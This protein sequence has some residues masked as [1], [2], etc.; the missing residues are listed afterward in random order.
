MAMPV[1]EHAE[2]DGLPVRRAIIGVTLVQAL[3]TMAAFTPAAVAP[4]L[5]KALGVPTSMI[6]LQVGIVYAGAMV[7]SFISGGLVRRWGGLR[8][9][10]TALVLA[11]LGTMS[12]TLP[13]LAAVAFGSLLVGIGYGCTN[14][15][16]AHVLFR[17]APPARRNLI[18][19]IKQAGQPL[20]GVLA[21]LLAPPL[22]V[23]FGLAWA[24]A[25]AGLACLGWLIF[26]QT[27]RD[28]IDDD[29]EPA[30]PVFARPFAD[31]ALV[32][33]DQALRVLA[34]AACCFGAVQLAVTTFLV[35][36]LVDEL[37]LSLIVAG[38][39]L[40]AHQV[41]GVV[42]RMFWG[43]VADR[44]GDGGR[45]LMV[46]AGISAASTLVCVVLT[47]ASPFALVITL[48]VLLGLSAVGWNGVFQ[49]EVALRAPA[50]RAGNAT[51]GV[52]V[53]AFVGVFGGP[54]LFTAV[55][56][57]TASYAE[58]YGW[59]AVGSL[60]GLLLV[61]VSRRVDARRTG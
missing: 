17:L 60:L 59:L 19:S 39:V 32:W 18:F 42:G 26:M 28:R 27:F 57:L 34:G 52:M 15:S 43:A 3:V 54:P 45:T 1:N 6:G 46:I 24:L 7:M 58:A 56:E 33:R 14:P 2:K 25:A 21:G 31:L 53:M 51:A 35:A 47:P 20:G 61:A 4:A 41:A 50:G 37:G 16:A 5:A 44:V 48:F 36:M 13:S 9:S 8:T 49:A 23:N 55:H 11:A 22:A 29:R 40:A 10:Q 38:A 30:Y 12:M